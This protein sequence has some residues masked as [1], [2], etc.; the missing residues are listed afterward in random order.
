[1][2]N[3]DQ[4]DT[5]IKS[6]DADTSVY[7]RNKRRPNRVATDFSLHSTRTYRDRGGR[8]LDLSFFHSITLKVKGTRAKLPIKSP[9]DRV[10]KLE[11]RKS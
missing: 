7:E 3:I 9:A 1:M 5:I 8:P 11:K 4:G 2:G 6:G 10:L